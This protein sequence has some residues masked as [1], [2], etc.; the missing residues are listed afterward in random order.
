[1]TGPLGLLGGSFDPVHAGHC[2]LARDAQR[3]LG[4]EQLR[5]IPAGRP[6]QK[7]G[8]TAA[9]HRVAMLQLALAGT[10]GWTI[11]R[12]EID[13]PGPTYTVDTLQALRA[14]CGAQVPLVWILGQDQLQRLDSWHRWQDLLGL[15]HLAYADRAGTQPDL[16]PALRDYVAAHR[17]DPGTLATRPAGGIVSFAMQPVHC[18][19]T[20]LRQAL[21][22]GDAAAVA[23]FL[24]APV[25]AYIHTHQLYLAANGQ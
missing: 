11:D 24:A 6:W 1:M 21:A 12:C 9:A 23:P 15:A 4:L 7:E 5:F 19:A 14:E 18:S 16:A 8:V 20:G 25:L 3:S 10:A 2:Q 22:A 13:R 17:I